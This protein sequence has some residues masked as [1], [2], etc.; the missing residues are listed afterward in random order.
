M[1]KVILNKI[2]KNARYRIFEWKNEFYLLDCD[3]SILAILFPISIYFK[4]HKC[5]QLTRKEY[6][7]LEQV[8]LNPYYFFGIGL[9]ILLSTTILRRFIVQQ[10]LSN[11]PNIDG[12]WK[13]ILLT[14]IFLVVFSFRIF[15]S[16][17]LLIRGYNQNKDYILIKLIPINWKAACGKIFSYIFILFILITI[18]YGILISNEVN[19]VIVLGSVPFLLLILFSNISMFDIE[20][21]KISIHSKLIKK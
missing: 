7:E 11:I 13:A 1:N 14:L 21:Y 10:L 19:Y 4:I 9:S 20:K 12:L 16:R 15:Y 5:Y 3:S 17:K 8:I 6:E 18:V 2:N